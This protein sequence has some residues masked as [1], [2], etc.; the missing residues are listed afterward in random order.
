MKNIVRKIVNGVCRQSRN[1]ATRAR[2]ALPVLAAGAVTFAAVGSAKAEGTNSG[3]DA[4]VAA[5]NGLKPD[6]G[7]V[8]LAGIGLALIGIGACVALNLGK[9][10][11]GK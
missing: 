5:I 9:K 1:L 8:V 2:R 11:M 6:M 3:V 7:T 4:I 10:I